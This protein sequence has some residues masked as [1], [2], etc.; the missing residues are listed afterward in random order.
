IFEDKEELRMPNAIDAYISKFPKDVQK[1][2]KQ[3]R[4]VIKKAAPLAVEKMTYGMPTYYLH[5]NLV[6]F[7][8]AK[9]HYEFYPAPSGITAFKRDLAK[10]KTSKGAVQIPFDGPLP[11]TLIQKITRY[12]V[13]ENMAQALTKRTVTKKTIDVIP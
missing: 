5:K 13:K 11:L 8:A 12:R 10:Y 7:A 9:S 4:A 2:L 6:H 1:G 3:I